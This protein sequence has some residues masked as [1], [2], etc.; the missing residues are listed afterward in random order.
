MDWASSLL[1]TNSYKEVAEITN[2]SKSTLIR[3][4]KKR[5]M[6][7]AAKISETTTVI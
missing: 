5:K 1:D 6:A 3:E 4:V 7:G 2:I